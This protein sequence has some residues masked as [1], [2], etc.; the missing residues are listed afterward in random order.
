MNV[1]FRVDA[2]KHIGA[3]HLVRC[4]NLAH[5]IS[6]R[7]AKIQFVCRDMPDKIFEQILGD[8]FAVMVLPM[9]PGETISQLQD[10]QE[11]IQAMN[12]MV[13]DWLVVD[14]YA[15]DMAW[16]TLLR[17]YTG[18]LLVIDDHAS[19]RHDCD[20]LLDQNYSLAGSERYAGRVPSHC[21]LMLGPQDALLPEKFKK[22][23]DQLTGKTGQLNRL[24]IFFTAGNDQHETMKAMHGVAQFGHVAGVDVVIGAAN[25]NKNEIEAMCRQNGWG[26]HCQVDYMHEL[27]ANA[28]LAIGAGGIS[29]WERCALGVPALIV[30]LAENQVAIA[31]DL[32]TAGVIINMGKSEG[33]HPDAYA[34]QLTS[35]TGELLRSMSE[36]ARKLVDGMG[37]G[38]VTQHIYQN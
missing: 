20:L 6:G 33:M 27:L 26:Y 28:D 5:A 16:E 2:A 3:G 13:P 35:M 10:A 8:Q 14:S 18:K 24:L 17:P 34:I 29:N 32:A 21:K 31:N 7:G 25:E 9:G 4:L 19:R 15:L 37:P 12:G 36:N 38:R 30:V 1:V 23:R 22:A 11:T